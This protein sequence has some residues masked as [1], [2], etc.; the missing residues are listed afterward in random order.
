[1]PK[2]F[3]SP[4]NHNQAVLVTGAGGGIG[5]ATA[6]AFANAGA[7]VA[8]LDIDKSSLAETVELLKGAG[9]AIVADL[10]IIKN[11]PSILDEAESKVGPI[12][13]LA[14]VAAVLRR[15]K[16]VDVTED[17]WDFHLDLNAKASFFLGREFAERLKRGNRIGAVVTTSSQSWWTGGLDGAIVYAASK[18]A[19]VTLTRG[20][21]RRYGPSN[22]RF[23]SVAPGFVDTQMLRSGLDD[24]AI[25]RMLSATPLGRLAEPDEVANAIVFLA[26]PA[27]SYITGATLVV[28]GGQLMF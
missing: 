19:L 2:I 23:N 10:R 20:F 5:R 4:N 11:F 7:Q 16:V 24:A 18:G 22:I 26:S 27:S 17:D 3:T 6:L 14:L 21:A 1:M 13:A 12:D 25:D 9:H 15:L 8:C 28:A